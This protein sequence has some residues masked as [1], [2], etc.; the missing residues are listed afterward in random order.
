MRLALRTITQGPDHLR[1]AAC[2]LFDHG[3]HG[4][5]LDELECQPGAQG[6]LLEQVDGNPAGLLLGIVEGQRRKCGV[7][8][9]THSGILVYPRLFFSGKC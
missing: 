5:T 8:Q 6:Y 1:L 3:L 2:H 7:D 9:Y 4:V